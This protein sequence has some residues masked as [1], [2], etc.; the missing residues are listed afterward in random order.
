[1]DKNENE[2][3]E[4]ILSGKVISF[5]LVVEKYQQMVFTVALGFLQ[6]I[7]DAQD[8]TQDVFVS[9][10]LGLR[11]FRGDCM[12]STWIYRIAI[13]KSL[14]YLRKHKKNRKIIDLDEWVMAEAIGSTNNYSSKDD[15]F[16]SLVTSN[17]MEIFAKALETLPAKQRSAFILSKYKDLSQKEIAQVMKIG[18][19][20]VESLLQRAKK[21]LRKILIKYLD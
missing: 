20:A 16:R 8:V 1:M 11:K 18:E 10:Y 7:D 14:E 19:K 5:E 4:E 3:L 12:L 2:I 15:A 13:N 21:G 9:V 6:N 17:T